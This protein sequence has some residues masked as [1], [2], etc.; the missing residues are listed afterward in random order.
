MLP[1]CCS[2]GGPNF[3]ATIKLT[4]KP[5]DKYKGERTGLVVMGMDYA[6]LIREYGQRAGSLASILFE[7]RQRYTG[8]S[9]RYGRPD[10]QH[11]LS[12]SKIQQRCQQEDFK[13]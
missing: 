6:G 7:G 1:I 4:F 11:H 5:V 2:E 12:E 13:E 10:R 9:K 8:T 3:T